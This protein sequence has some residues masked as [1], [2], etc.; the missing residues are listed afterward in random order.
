M[1]T[2]LTK[3]AA[4]ILR[5]QVNAML[6]APGTRDGRIALS[7]LL[8]RNLHDSRQYRGYRYLEI[9]LEGVERYHAFLD[10]ARADGRY[11]DAYNAEYKLRYREAFG[12]D[13]R[14]EYR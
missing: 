9:S 8:E 3:K 4:T 13:S 10:R 11:D 2:K 12:D 14:R 1:T 6:A 7:V 5:D